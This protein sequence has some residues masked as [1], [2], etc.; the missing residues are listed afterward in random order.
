MH[1]AQAEV[2]GGVLP[3]LQAQL[4]RGRKALDAAA[5]ADKHAVLPHARHVAVGARAGLGL[6]RKPRQA[7]QVLNS[8]SD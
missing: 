8:C 7:S 6:L 5:E 4:R 1:L 2:L 3:R